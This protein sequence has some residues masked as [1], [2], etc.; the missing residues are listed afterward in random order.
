MFDWLKCCQLQF[1]SIKLS[2]MRE[3]WHLEVGIFDVWGIYFDL[4]NRGIG[5]HSV[6][7]CYNCP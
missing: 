6:V 3:L 7:T 2:V 1:S 5:E 4:F